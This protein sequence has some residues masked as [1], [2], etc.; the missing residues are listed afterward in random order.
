MNKIFVKIDKNEDKNDNYTYSKQYRYKNINVEFTDC[1][2]PFFR[3]GI[4]CIVK[5]ESVYR[6]LILYAL[7]K[8]LLIN[9]LRLLLF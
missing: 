2:F 8:A 9:V 1:V 6:I 5:K 3:G 4:P 7:L